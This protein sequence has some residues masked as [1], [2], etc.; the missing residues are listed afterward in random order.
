MKK[1]G[2]PWGGGGAMACED[3]SRESTKKI[4]GSRT[5]DESLNRN[6]GGGKTENCT[7]TKGVRKPGKSSTN[8]TALK[9][10]TGSPIARNTFGETRGGGSP[11][12][13]I[14]L[15]KGIGWGA[16]R[17]FPFEDN[18]SLGRGGRVTESVPSCERNGGG[19]AAIR[20]GAPKGGK[21]EQENFLGGDENP[22]KTTEG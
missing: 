8:N 6:L 20:R 11:E 3:F 15:T 4:I 16:G 9:K 19:E 14:V 18:F 10:R 21:W 22:G 17:A 12:R 13:A 1:K 2:A 5:R 7:N